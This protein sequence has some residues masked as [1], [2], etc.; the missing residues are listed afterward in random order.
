MKKYVVSIIV[1]LALV[2]IFF[3]GKHFL[4]HT[5]EGAKVLVNMGMEDKASSIKTPE[6]YVDMEEIYFNFVN[7]KMLMS[8]MLTGK[9]Q[10]FEFMDDLYY[11]LDTTSGKFPDMNGADQYA[12]AT[13]GGVYKYVF[14]IKGEYLAYVPGTQDIEMKPETAIYLRRLEER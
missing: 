4:F 11:E 5:Y 10:K 8:N 14:Y 6:Y 7:G 3:C 13:R 1:V 2:V 12:Y 9:A